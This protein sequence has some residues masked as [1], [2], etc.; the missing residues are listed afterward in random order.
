M[1]TAIRDCTLTLCLR[2]LK[3]LEHLQGTD[4][5]VESH[6]L[7]HELLGVTDLLQNLT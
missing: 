3:C 4:G 7:E 6:D 1:A 5:K 2:H